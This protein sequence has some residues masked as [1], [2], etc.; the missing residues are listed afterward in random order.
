MTET[1]SQTEQSDLPINRKVQIDSNTLEMVVRLNGI[2]YSLTADLINDIRPA[3]RE[4]PNE[5]N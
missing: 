2:G 3:L 1:Q 5:P 4:N